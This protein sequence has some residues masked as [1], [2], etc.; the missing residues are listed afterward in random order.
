MQE[1][2]LNQLS[3]KVLDIARAAGSSI[4]DIYHDDTIKV[5]TKNDGSPVTSADKEAHQIIKAGLEKLPQDIPILS[6][7]E[8]IS[9]ENL[10]L[11]W[12]VDPLDGTKEFIN[13]TDEFTVNIALVLDS[14]P[15]M[16]VV[17]A[18]A[19]EEEFLGILN[20]GSY[21]ITENKKF[22]IKPKSKVGDICTITT[23][24]SH[25]SDLDEAFL[26]EANKRFRELNLKQAGSSLK[27]CRVAEGAAD[28]Y[29]RL[30]PT[31]Q[32]DIAAGQVIAEAAGAVLKSTN[33]KDL[34]YK[35]DSKTKNPFFYC[36]GDAEFNWQ[37]L[38][39]RALSNSKD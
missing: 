38:L 21:K 39:N 30:G 17:I 4:L 5:E 32:W 11:F 1:L 28:I 2:N 19:I 8:E 36:A 6:E 25:K 33:G 13:R 18:P 37:D 31:Y 26:K 29:S 15:V 9:S 22:S 27:L 23:S 34:S 24:K 14:R 20:E 16:G 12:L 10:D 3:I 35:F 7:E